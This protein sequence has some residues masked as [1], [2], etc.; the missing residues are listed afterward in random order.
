MYRDLLLAQ[1]MIR[2]IVDVIPNMLI[3]EAESARLPYV[4][5]HWGLSMK[6]TGEIQ[7]AI[8]AHYKKIVRFYGQDS[9]KDVMKVYYQKHRLLAKLV[10]HLVYLA[11]MP[12]FASITVLDDVTVKLLID[13]FLGV[14]LLGFA[15]LATLPSALE[16]DMAENVKKSRE[17]KT[18]V[19]VNTAA[20]GDVDALAIMRGYQQQLREKLAEFLK[21]VIEVMMMSRKSV[22]YSYESAMDDVHR[23]K[24]KEKDHIVADFAE[25]PDEQREIEDLLKRS[26]LGKWSK[27]LK[28]SVFQYVAEDYDEE[29]EEMERRAERERRVGKDKDVTDM[30]RD[31]YMEEMEADERSAEEIDRDAYDMSHIGEDDDDGYDYDD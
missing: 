17:L 31:I 26:K 7:E 23:V 22:D 12:G 16:T 24:E 4:P 18:M 9:L 19:D 15:K 10:E 27:G 28:K 20:T 6:H 3:N 11:P 13:Y 5:K 2:N 29:R 30:N 8:T 14:A 1:G 25:L 21:S